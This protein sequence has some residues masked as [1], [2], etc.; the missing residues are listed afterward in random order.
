[1]KK[2][3][4]NLFKELIISHLQKKTVRFVSEI[5]KDIKHSEEVIEL[6]DTARTAFDAAS[7]LKVPVGAIV[8]TLI[9]II[10]QEDLEIP[11]VTLISGDKKCKINNLTKILNI[12]G[13]I[14]R[15]NAKYVKELTGYSIGCVSPIGLPQELTIIIDSSLKRFG[16]IWSAAGHTHCVFSAT[17]AQLK[18]ITNALESHEVT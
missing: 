4:H 5:L 10:Q 8:K 16:K 17:F 7:A 15:P 6:S 2:I 9:F 18:Q 3:F 13:T 14:E 12:K 1:M 11:V